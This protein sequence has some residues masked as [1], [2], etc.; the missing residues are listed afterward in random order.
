MV[1]MRSSSGPID[2][3]LQGG[4]IKAIGLVGGMDELERQ[5]IRVKRIAGASGGA[6]V[7]G[8]SASGY[9]PTD[10][11]RLIETEPFPELLDTRWYARLPAIGK[12]LAV[13]LRMGLHPGDRLLERL[14]ELLADR[15]VRTF[16]DLRDAH[17]YD[18]LQVVVSDITAR[19]ILLLPR[20]AVLFGIEPD[21]LEVALA[22]RMSSSIPIIYEPV[23]LTSV[24]DSTE[25]LL[26][27]GGMLSNFPLWIFDRQNDPETEVI[28]LRLVEDQPD[29]GLVDLLPVPALARTRFG[30]L[31]D[32]VESMARTLMEAHDRRYLDAGEIA[33][34]VPVPTLGVGTTEFDLSPERA[35][36]LYQAGQ[37]AVRAILEPES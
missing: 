21:E 29:T 14:S 25:H 32:Y 33:R 18:P 5:Q 19:R 9:T 20:D 31:V 34:T 10:L 28:G 11:R 26:V 1:L 16:G 27:D 22:L 7:A 30:Q 4:G 17:P 2:L 37:Q 8:L 6:V 35:E 15:G 36:A 13:L 24:S 23:R 12:P 3:V